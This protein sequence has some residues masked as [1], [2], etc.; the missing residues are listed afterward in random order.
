MFLISELADLG[1]VYIYIYIYIYI[2]SFVFLGSHLGHM[3]IPRLGVQLEPQLLAY[4]T[5]IAMKDPSHIFELHHSSW[6]C[7]ILNPLSKARDRTHI[8]MDTSWVV[9]HRASVGTPRI[10]LV[11]RYILAL[12]KCRMITSLTFF[13]SNRRFKPQRPPTASRVPGLQEVIWDIILV[14]TH[15]HAGAVIK[16]C[17]FLPCKIPWFSPS[18]F[19]C[20]A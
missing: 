16:F 4:T 1:Y 12:A 15:P 11:L 10:F 13:F 6:Q 5:A 20:Q 7:K 2:L 9:S 17:Y 19:L 14:F 18:C 3:E 8:L